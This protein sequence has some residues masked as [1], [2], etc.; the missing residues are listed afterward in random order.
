MIVI[1]IIM[2]FC[3]GGPS[4]F[5]LQS[6]VLSI[7]PSQDQRGD[8]Q[9]HVLFAYIITLLYLHSCMYNYLII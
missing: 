9:V 3:S 8:H 2:N 5:M 6:E 7:R 1:I 4:D